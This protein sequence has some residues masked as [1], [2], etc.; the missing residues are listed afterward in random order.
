MHTYN[1]GKVRF[2]NGG[3][4]T[5]FD[6]AQGP[7]VN[8]LHGNLYALPY[9]FNSQPD[10]QNLNLQA[11]FN[12][13]LG[14]KIEMSLGT[15]G[16]IL[17][18]FGQPRNQI[19]LTQAYVQYTRGPLTFLAGKFV[20]LAGFEAVET[21]KNPNYSHGYLPG[22]AVPGTLT[23]VRATYAPNPKI[24]V[25]V[26][27]NDGWDDWQFLG[28]GLT[29]AGNVTFAPSP[30]VSLAVTTYNGKDYDGQLLETGHP[31]GNRMLYD[32]ILIVHPVSALELV[33]NYDNGTQ[34]N[35]AR[36]DSTGAVI[37]APGTT[38]PILGSDNWNGFAGYAVYSFS[39]K[40]YLALRAET[41]EDSGGFRTGFDQR[42]QSR[43][44]TFAYSPSPTYTFRVE[45]RTDT[46]DQPTFQQRPNLSST[47]G[48]TYQNALGFEG[49]ITL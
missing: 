22:F 9:D 31:Y 5:I 41:F 36:A 6:G 27:A 21:P 13:E 49:I 18:S 34:L 10:L 40:Y 33:V 46:S 8:P 4:S 16:D 39:S 1:T 44:A 28:K 7:F 43:T 37:L 25:S 3:Q 24:S 17:A 14:G 29:L 20:A 45:Y 19:N 12:G 47:P 11:T 42:L 26:G 38:T 30:A 15:D 23:G 2:V 48:R 32:V 35:A